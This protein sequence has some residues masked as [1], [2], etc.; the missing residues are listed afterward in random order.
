MPDRVEIRGGASESE[1][2]VIAVVLDRIE[3]ED[4]AARE[5]RPDTYRSL[6]AWV[7]AESPLAPDHPLDPPPR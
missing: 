6:P 1:A 3:Q 2:A 7:L 4:R 5:M